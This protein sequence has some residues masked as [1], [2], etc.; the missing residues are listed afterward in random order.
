MR[1]TATILSPAVAAD[2]RS[3]IGWL[4]RFRL[5]NSAATGMALLALAPMLPGSS[6]NAAEVSARIEIPTATTHVIGDPIPLIWHFTNATDK[7]LAFV[8]EACCRLNG[9][10]DIR[11]DGHA[12]PTIPPGPG[13]AHQ[14]AKPAII[15]PTG[16]QQF[17]SMLADWAFLTNSGRYEISGRYVGVVEGQRPPVPASISLWRDQAITPPATVDLLS[18]P[19]YLAQRAERSARRGL[20]A[21]VTGPDKLPPVGAASFQVRIRNTSSVP[22][23]IRWPFD[24]DLWLVDRGGLRIFR[25]PTK[26]DVAAKELV[27]APGADVTESFPVSVDDLNNAPLGDYG[28]FIDFP[29]RD[30]NPRVPSTLHPLRWDPDLDAVAD[31]LGSAADGRSVGARN[32]PLRRLR[33]YLSSLGPKM[34]QLPTNGLSDKAARLRHD[35]LLADCLGDLPTRTGRTTLGAEALPGGKWRFTEPTVLRCTQGS[36]AEQLAQVTSVRRHLGLEIA[37]NLRPGASCTVADMIAAA[38]SIAGGNTDLANRPRFIA[39]APT[40]AVP[41]TVSFPA[42]PPEAETRFRFGRN[43]SGTPVRR[44]EVGQAFEMIL[45]SAEP[46]R[47]LR[48]PA[49]LAALLEAERSTLQPLLQCDA[50]VRWSQLEPW[51]RPFLERGFQIDLVATGVAQPE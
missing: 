30:G 10:V 18:V 47:L 29:E 16:E 9:R 51:L 20:D 31:L 17:E 11:H 33:Q 5:V 4:G 39:E 36:P 44:A 26:P 12:L 1:R 35:L 32:A 41:G 38:R 42:E 8:W 21:T 6:A 23:S 28:V 14:F 40:N 48:R 37:I 22:L 49:E 3:R 19:D 50:Q 43:L 34:A 13:T 25:S 15:G 2:V 46:P 45:Q 24:A 7:P 27:V